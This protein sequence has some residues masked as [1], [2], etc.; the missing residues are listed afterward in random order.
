MVFRNSSYIVHR[1]VELTIKATFI[2][3]KLY[4]K[5]DRTIEKTNNNISAQQQ[6]QH[7]ACE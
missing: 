5:I 2:V 4:V 3:I 1:P 7:M 6:Q